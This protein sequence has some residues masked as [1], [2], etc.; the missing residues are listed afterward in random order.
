MEMYS[1]VGH[2]QIITT[3]LIIDP[4]TNIQD[5]L[6]LIS[7]KKLVWVSEDTDARFK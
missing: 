4:E 3:L 5:H 2:M 7:C 6:R 1:Y